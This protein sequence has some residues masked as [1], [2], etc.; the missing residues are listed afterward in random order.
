MDTIRLV[1]ANASGQLN[2]IPTMAYVIDYIE[3]DMPLDVTDGPSVV[4]SGSLTGGSTYYSSV[5]P[6]VRFKPN[7][8]VYLNAG[9]FSGEYTAIIN[10]TTVGDMN[11]YMQTDRGRNA[12]GEVVYYPTP[13]R[14]R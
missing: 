8:T 2:G 6:N 9:N 10:Y 4:I 1:G 14:F 12:R 3:I 11:C 7:E 5:K 13:W